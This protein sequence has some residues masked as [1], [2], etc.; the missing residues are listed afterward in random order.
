MKQEELWGDPVES[1]SLQGGEM[2][3]FV[4]P[5]D[6]LVADVDVSPCLPY[7]LV[8][9]SS[10]SRGGDEAFEDHHLVLDLHHDVCPRMHCESTETSS[11]P[12]D[13]FD[14]GG[15]RRRRWRR[16]TRAGK[17]VGEGTG[18]KVRVHGNLR[19]SLE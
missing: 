4:I 9:Q 16:R 19:S 14:V 10:Q 13:E 7:V 8:E 17:A 1:P 5:D 6:E 15:K 2:S 11:H 12:V 3:R 18:R